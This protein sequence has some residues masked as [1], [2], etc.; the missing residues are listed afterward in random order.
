MKSA[1][2]FLIPFDPISCVWLRP[3]QIHAASPKRLIGFLHPESTSG[4]S[5]DSFRF[6]QKQFAV[7]HFEMQRRITEHP[8]SVNTHDLSRENPAARQRFETH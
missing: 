5:G 6:R 1:A 2:K 3:E 8:R 7:P 4:V